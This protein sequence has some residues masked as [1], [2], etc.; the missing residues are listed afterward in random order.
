[1]TESAAAAEISL[2][3]QIQGSRSRQTLGRSGWE[4]PNSGEFS[5]EGQTPLLFLHRSLDK[6]VKGV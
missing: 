1:M 6:V 5:Y 4:I 2:R 3:P